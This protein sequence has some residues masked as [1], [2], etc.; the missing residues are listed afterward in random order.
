[1]LS[2]YR[3]HTFKRDRDPHIEAK[4]GMMLAKV[5]GEPAAIVRCALGDDRNRMRFAALVRGAAVREAIAS[6]SVGTS[7]MATTSAPPAIPAINA[8]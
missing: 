1:M 2:T 4:A 8:R 6:G 3:C 5:A 7:G